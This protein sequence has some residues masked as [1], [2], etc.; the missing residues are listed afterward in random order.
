[1]RG[2]RNWRG[3]KSWRVF[4]CFFCRNWLYAPVLHTNP[5]YP[6]S[7]VLVKNITRQ[8]KRNI[9]RGGVFETGNFSHSSTSL[10]FVFEKS[11]KHSRHLRRYGFPVFPFCWNT[12]GK[13]VEK[14][15]SLAKTL[16]EHLCFDLEPHF[17]LKWRLI[18]G[19]DVAVSVP[20]LSARK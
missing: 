18:R 3:L 6:V 14:K 8:C 19:I 16:G 13:L 5:N 4:L 11:K 2:F 12:F 15:K 10:N 1:M 20:D 9:R 17:V 7:L